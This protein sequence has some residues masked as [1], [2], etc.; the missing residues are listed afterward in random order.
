MFYIVGITRN[1][2]RLAVCSSAA[3]AA[4]YIATLPG[5]EDGRFYIDACRDTVVLDAP[6]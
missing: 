1:C 4:E 3:R 6:A 5:H 2:H